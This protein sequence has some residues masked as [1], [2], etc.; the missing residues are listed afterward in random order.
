MWIQVWKDLDKQW[1]QMFYYI[2]E[3]D[4]D[5]VIKYWED[6]W[7]IKVL[8]QELSER[9]AEEE[10]GYGETQPPEVPIPKK[11]R[12]S[13]KKKQRQSRQAKGKLRQGPRREQRTL[14]I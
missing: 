8:T 12:T 3:G 1:L 9:T 2:R 11:W 10:V 4:I 6:E 13:Q 14:C 7:K 5:M